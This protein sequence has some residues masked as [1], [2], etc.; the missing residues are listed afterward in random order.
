VI[1]AMRAYL[2]LLYDRLNNMWSSGKPMFSWDEESVEEL[3][4]PEDQSAFRART[5]SFP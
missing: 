5:N 1:S 2:Q 3:T 4:P